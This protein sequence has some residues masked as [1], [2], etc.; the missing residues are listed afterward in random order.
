MSGMLTPSH[1]AGQ[2]VKPRW[3]TVGGN[4]VR[5]FQST[6]RVLFG[7]TSKTFTTME[8]VHRRNIAGPVLNVRV[9]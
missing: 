1:L 4:F 7:L 8:K 2:K 5:Q 3:P 6:S 9:F